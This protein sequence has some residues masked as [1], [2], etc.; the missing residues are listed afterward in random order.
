MSY[1]EKIAER[2]RRALQEETSISEQ[3]MFGGLCFLKNGRMCVGITNDDLV[4]RVDPDE[5]SGLLKRPHVRPM[6]FTGRPFRGFVYLA[7]AGY[8]SSA[9]LRTWITRG[10]AAAAQAAGPR[11]KSL[12]AKGVPQSSRNVAIP[13]SRGGPG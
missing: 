13:R 4:V 1:D 5:L 10:L 6:T 12:R 3:K 9:A 8:S 2:I 11:M 7:P